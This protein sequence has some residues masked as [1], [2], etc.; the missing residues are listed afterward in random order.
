MFSMIVKYYVRIKVE[1]DFG[2]RRLICRCRSR[3]AI[4][5]IATTMNTVVASQDAR[6]MK[7]V[8]L[9]VCLHRV[10]YDDVSTPQR[11][12]HHRSSKP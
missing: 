11:M 3:L 4:L 1:E 2:N 12:L 6:R 5:E 7:E 8:Q 9:N 10:N